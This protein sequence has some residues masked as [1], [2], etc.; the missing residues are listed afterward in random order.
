MSLQ[1]EN[2]RASHDVRKTIVYQCDKEIWR[3]SYSPQDGVTKASVSRNS[4][5]KIEGVGG[6]MTNDNATVSAE[7]P[8]RGTLISLSISPSCEGLRPSC[9]VL[10][11]NSFFEAFDLFEV[12]SRSFATASVD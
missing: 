11:M 8:L 10:L 1:N 12:A 9:M 6:S 4:P 7:V 5:S 3:L 2:S